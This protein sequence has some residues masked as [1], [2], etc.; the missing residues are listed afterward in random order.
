MFGFRWLQ[1]IRLPL[2][3]RS[4]ISRGG[5]GYIWGVPGFR[6]GRSPSG[7]KWVSLGLPGTG[8]SFFKY[9][10]KEPL[11]QTAIFVDDDELVEFSDENRTN[12]TN[13]LDRKTPKPKNT[14]KRVIR[15]WKNIR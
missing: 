10:S 6:V 2:G 7:R 5:V 8:L 11:G 3:F 15:K 9:I 12:H 1:R 13:Q 4:T 14:R